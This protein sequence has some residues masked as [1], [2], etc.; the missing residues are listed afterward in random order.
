MP[1]GDVADVGFEEVEAL[2]DLGSD[3]AHGQHVDP[4]RRQ[5]DP[6]RHPTGQAKNLRQWVEVSG[7]ENE[8]GPDPP[9]G[10]EE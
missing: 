4:R 9:G 5:Q 6:D 7:L 1:F 10:I 3:L 2:G 8:S